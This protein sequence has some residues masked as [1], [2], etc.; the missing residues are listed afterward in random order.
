M[1]FLA[2]RE[3]DADSPPSLKEA[4]A[5]GWTDILVDDGP[6]WTHTGLCPECRSEWDAVF[7][8]HNRKERVLCRRRLNRA[9]TSDES[10]AGRS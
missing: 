10:S 5:H 4:R 2:C 1:F 9:S 7:S 6:G 8:T 3:C